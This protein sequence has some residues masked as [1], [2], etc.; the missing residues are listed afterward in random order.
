MKKNEF[1][2]MSNQHLKCMYDRRSDYIRYLESEM[3]NAKQSLED[4]KQA[5]KL[6]GDTEN[7]H[8]E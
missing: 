5:M 2:G 7:D 8:M 3:H 4:I 6:S 1:N